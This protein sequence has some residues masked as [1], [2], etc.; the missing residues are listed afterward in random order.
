[1]EDS[2]EVKPSTIPNAGFGLFA[3]R[4]LQA[5]E[6][7]AVY[8]GEMKRTAEEPPSGDYVYMFP[9]ECLEGRLTEDQIVAL[10]WRGTYRDPQ[11]TWKP[12]HM[13]RWINHHQEKRNVFA[14][15]EGKDADGGWVL[16]FF[17]M[18]TIE[19]GEELFFDYGPLYNLQ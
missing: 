11:T 10:K 2:V 15:I 5:D 18:R 14:D 4:Q 3:K 8:G 12:E 6:R 9:E 16:A 7:V 17:A 13:G 1:M 19:A